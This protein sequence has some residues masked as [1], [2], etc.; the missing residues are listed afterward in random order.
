MGWHGWWSPATWRC[1]RG[2]VTPPRDDGGM[3]PFIGGWTP[4]HEA[5]D[6][7]TYTYVKL[8]NEHPVP[9]RRRQR[10]INRVRVRTRLVWPDGV[11]VIETVAEYYAGRLVLVDVPGIRRSTVCAWLDASD[12]DRITAPE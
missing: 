8:L 1:G 4:E 7:S 12:V 5:P 3:S 10:K 2:D 11:E 9:E 6:V